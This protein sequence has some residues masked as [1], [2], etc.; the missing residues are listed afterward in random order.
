MFVCF[1]V[2][3]GYPV[4][5][6][7]SNQT[8]SGSIEIYYNK[9][10]GKVFFDFDMTVAEVVCRQL[11]CGPAISFA[12]YYGYVNFW[13][14]GVSCLGIERSLSECSISMSS[15]YSKY[16]LYAGV[17]CSGEKNIFF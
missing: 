7:G 9:H 17:S 2:H 11:G 8:C 13:G 12:Y 6:S 1:Y 10:W 15:E 3:I 5:L 4:R 14:V 16:G